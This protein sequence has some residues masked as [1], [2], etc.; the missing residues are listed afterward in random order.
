MNVRLVL[1]SSPL[2]MFE[3][4]GIFAGAANTQ[5]AFALVCLAAVAKVAGSETTIIDASAENLSTEQTL[6]KI[7][8]LKPD[9]LGITSTT[10]GITSAGNLA[11]LVKE[12]LPNTIVII[13]GC[14]AS[15]LPVDTLNEFKAFDLAVIGEGENTLLDILK[16]VDAKKQTPER[17]QGTAHRSGTQVIVNEPRALLQNL[18][19]LPLPAWSLLKGFP[20]SFQP[21]PGRIRRGPC[22]SIVLTRGCPNSC[23]FCDR[24]VFGHRCRS[25]SPS[26]AI[27]LLKDLRYNHGVKEILIE[28]DTFIMSSTW[29]TE[30]CKMIISEE[31][32][33]SW[34]CL[35]RADRINSDL[36]TTMKRAGCWHISFGI[37]SGDE[38]LLKKTNKRLDISQIRAAVECCRAAN[39]RT[40]GFFMIG[41]PGESHESIRLTRELSLSLPLNDISV[42]QLTPFPGTE[43]YANAHEYGQFERDWRK[44]NT[45]NTVFIP[46]GFTKN[47]MEKAR[48]DIIRA[49]YLR[50]NVII[51]HLIETL[52]H[53]RLIVPML[54]SI[55]PLFNVMSGKSND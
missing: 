27:N 6:Q 19:E 29:V 3:R 39:L 24:S 9:I 8:A 50:P 46:N 47:D 40:K 28:D 53:P 44:M 23:T 38:R 43:I 25:Y 34:S 11:K 45:L 22:A 49:F 42:M 5:P 54:K 20:S 26:Y 30:F 55:P 48:S 7:L 31:I 16:S 12:S 35:G 37:E 33:I 4:Y 41:F 14:H 17:L 1:T 32:D 21:S 51:D 52:H 36:A 15:A 2:S 18:D 10:V 13:G